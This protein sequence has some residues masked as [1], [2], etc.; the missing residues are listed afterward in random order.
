LAS[1]LCAVAGDLAQLTAARVLQG[2]GGGVMSPVALTMLF[3]AYPPEQRI[4]LSRVLILPTAIAPA[5]GP[6]LGGFFVE[7][8]N[9]RWGFYVNLPVGALA[10]VYGWKFL[11][12]HVESRAKRFDGLGF[13]LAIPGLGLVMYA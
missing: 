11:A 12:E 9:W 5:L 6:V 1:L 10:L 4:K 7:Q 3:R 8:L 13:A 2:A